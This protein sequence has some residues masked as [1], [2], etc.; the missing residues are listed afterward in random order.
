MTR[1]PT[2]GGKTYEFWSE[3]NIGKEANGVG[4]RLLSFKSRS[5]E[6]QGRLEIHEF[7]KYLAG[8]GLL[9]A[10]EYVASVEF[11]NEIMGGEGTTW[12]KRLEVEV[13]P[14]PP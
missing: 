12:I 8:K 7:L 3:E 5:Q 10:N 2:I 1:S 14:A 11:G 6:P 13:E 9:N 4:W